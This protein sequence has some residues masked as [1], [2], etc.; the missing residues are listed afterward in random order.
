MVQN[1][2]EWML[3]KQPSSPSWCHATI[4]PALAWIQTALTQWSSLETRA[5]LPGLKYH[6]ADSLWGDLRLV[7]QLAELLMP[8]S[9]PC[10]VCLMVMPVP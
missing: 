7:T 6:S 2:T 8:G 5:R 4:L 3:S 9:L 1:T 10:K